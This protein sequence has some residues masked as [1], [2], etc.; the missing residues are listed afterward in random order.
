MRIGAYWKIADRLGCYAVG[1]GLLTFAVAAAWLLIAGPEGKTIP[2]VMGGL[3]SSPATIGHGVYFLAAYFGT[4]ILLA[5]LWTAAI[6]PLLF[7]FVAADRW[8]DVALASFLPVL[9]ALLV[10]NQSLFPRTQF[11]IEALDS[12][13]ADFLSTVFAVYACAV[14]AAGIIAWLSLA[15]RSTTGLRWGAA[16]VT[17]GGLAVGAFAVADRPVPAVE[18]MPDVIMIGADS[19]R[20]DHVGFLSG[21]APSLTPSL[22]AMLAGASVFERA[23]TPIGQTYAAWMSILTGRYPSAHGA[24]YNLIARETV[25]DGDNLARRFGDLGYHRIYAL[26]EVRFS[27]MDASYGFDI[28]VT[29]AMGAFDFFS[30][31]LDLPMV[32]LVSNHAVGGLFFPFSHINRAAPVSYRPEVFDARIRD[33]IEAAPAD[34][35]MFLIAHF[36][37]P[38]WPYEWADSGRFVID[39]PDPA[40]VRS[41]QPYQQAVRRVDQ[42][43]GALLEALADAGRLDNA[44]VVLLSDHGEAFTA[45]EPWWQTPV[46][47]DVADRRVF[48]GAVQGAVDDEERRVF[49]RSFHG[50]NVVSHAQNRVLLAFRGY[51]PQAEVVAERTLA[52]PTVSLVDIRPTIEAWVGIDPADD[53]DGESL[54]ALVK[55]GQSPALAARA[56]GVESGFSLPSIARGNPDAAEIIKAG[57]EYY[58]LDADGRLYLKDEWL[59]F[60]RTQKQRAAVLGDWMLTALPADGEGREQVFVLADFTTAQYWLEGSF[61]DGAPYASLLAQLCAIFADDEKFR[62][63]ACR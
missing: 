35:P 40:A 62:T 50:S 59:Q 13:S 7:R 15:A 33:A 30:T 4:H 17:S 38:H 25:D 1:F 39:S 32:N 43:Y 5:A 58:A 28:A 48:A 18:R 3:V 9:F 21:D 60:F 27:N 51:G 45:S 49:A 57:A 46:L 54:Y 34:R 6:A 29:P 20:P 10:W 8:S 47:D 36:E 19:L 14:V 52:G 23:W 16:A 53:L 22:D 41:P 56:V 44:V 31:H 63:D 55:G 37:L 12:G 61:P 11:A 2:T 24:Y 42:Q 26:D